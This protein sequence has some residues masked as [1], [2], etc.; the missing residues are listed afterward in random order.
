MPHLL[1]TEISKDFPTQ[2]NGVPWYTQ[3][4]L[5]NGPS[6][7]HC[8]QGLRSVILEALQNYLFRR[9]VT[10]FPLNLEDVK[11]LTQRNAVTYLVYR[12][13]LLDAEHAGRPDLA[14]FLL[15]TLMRL[16]PTYTRLQ[17]QQHNSEEIDRQIHRL[18]TVRE[19]LEAQQALTAPLSLIDILHRWTLHCRSI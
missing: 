7:A 9:L 11:E 8:F 12:Q 16:A 4:K 18:P 14:M 5:V 2:L 17:D 15:R 1:K 6:F 19:R 10:T 13:F 3:A